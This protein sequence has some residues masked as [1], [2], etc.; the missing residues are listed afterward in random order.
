VRLGKV[1]AGVADWGLELYDSNGNLTFSATDTIH[2]KVMKYDVS[3]LFQRIGGPSWPFVT[4]H[5]SIVPGAASF[6]GNFLI[7][8]DEDAKIF[9]GAVDMGCGLLKDLANVVNPGGQ[10][11]GAR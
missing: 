9:V 8:Q 1:G 5:N 6:D 3:H 10:V 2:A 7:C 4:A 11:M